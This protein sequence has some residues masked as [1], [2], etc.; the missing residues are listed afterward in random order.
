MN[1]IANLDKLLENCENL[2]NQLVYVEENNEFSEERKQIKQAL[3]KLIIAEAVQSRYVICVTGLQGVGK[4]SLIQD[5]YGL[6]IEKLAISEGRDEKIPVMISEKKDCTEIT[7]SAIE[8]N[9]G[10]N[11][12]YFKD[13]RVIQREEFI[14]I[15]RNATEDDG[16]MYMEV[17]LPYKHFKNEQSSFLLLPGF[18]YRMNYWQELIQFSVKT[19]NVA[20]FVTDYAAYN[21]L[22][23]KKLLDKIK[24]FFTVNSMICVVTQ[25][26]LYPSQN[27][28]S[29]KQLLSDFNLNEDQIILKG[30]YKEN[31]KNEEWRS[32]L[33]SA[34]TK[35][36][37]YGTQD[38]TFEL[39]TDIKNQ[40]KDSI[41]EIEEKLDEK[42]IDSDINKYKIDAT[43]KE[44]DLHLKKISSDWKKRLRKQLDVQKGITQESILKVKSD[45]IEEHLLK[46][47]LKKA[48]VLIFGEDEKDIYNKRILLK[49]RLQ[50]NAVPRSAIAIAK[51]F[52]NTELLTN[53]TGSDNIVTHYLMDET[54]SKRKQPS[55]NED[56]KAKLMNNI[57]ILLKGADAIGEDGKSLQFDENVKNLY[58]MLVEI[59]VYNFAKRYV[60]IMKEE[61]PTLGQSINVTEAAELLTKMEESKKLGL[62]MFALAGIDFIPDGSLNALKVLAA[63][64]SIP[65]GAMVGIFAG[66]MTIASL[67]T[68]TKDINTMGRKELEY[69]DECVDKYFTKVYNDTV[70]EFDEAMSKLRDLISKNLLEYQG[71]DRHKFAIINARHNV[72]ALKDNINDLYKAIKNESEIK[73]AGLLTD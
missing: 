61:C 14:D 2:Y 44:Y 51:S 70:T 32:N 20:L 64:L 54:E 62:G 55:I 72:V 33:T 30:R 46:S 10:S 68:L 41:F 7:Y 65:L 31:E 60:S 5:Y 56:N 29:R 57:S 4:T 19:S 27:E 48:S 71:V 67:T 21:Q 37:S 66:V 28:S 16:I 52:F 8:L 36:N 26:E 47:K 1:Y 35:Y 25:N 6:G 73:V 63:D 43:L 3:R 58:P 38:T 24:D 23:D 69:L 11:G 15:V 59:G 13:K 12:K 17:T 42:S 45:E 39:I 49:D 22:T 18:E 53:A 50:Y 40:I 34:I 9:I